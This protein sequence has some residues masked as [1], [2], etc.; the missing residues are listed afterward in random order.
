[1]VHV[2]SLKTCAHLAR[3]CVW[4]ALTNT[5]F[6]DESLA[7]QIIILDLSYGISHGFDITLD[8]LL[9]AWNFKD[10]VRFFSHNC[11]GNTHCL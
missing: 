3:R 7:I 11:I 2:S 10:I 4:I 8:L 1:M 9:I 6:M 5:L